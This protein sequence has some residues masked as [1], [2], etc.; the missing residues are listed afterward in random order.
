[1]TKSVTNEDILDL[2]QTSIT[3]SGEQFNLIDRRFEKIDR[4]F[5]KI[6]QR[7]EKIDQ[8]FE[9]ID[10]R[11]EKIDLRFEKIE[12]DLSVI[13]TT[14]STHSRDLYEIKNTIQKLSGEQKAQ[15]NDISDILDRIE[16]LTK[17]TAITQAEK[18]ELE[19]KLNQLIVWAKKVSKDCGVPLKI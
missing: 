6:D 16:E 5:E 14:Q 18:D 9:K 2:L 12:N 3:I 19:R 7:F 10:Q 13:K 4:R 1:M 8:R 11:F 17:R 15:L